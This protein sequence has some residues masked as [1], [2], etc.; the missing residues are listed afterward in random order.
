MG[1]C[2]F[3]NKPRLNRDYSSQCNEHNGYLYSK[4]K[5]AYGS[6]QTPKEYE[7]YLQQDPTEVARSL[8][9]CRI[10]TK[11]N[12]FHVVRTRYANYE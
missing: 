1:N 8:P 6:K 10:E 12:D 2:C 3:V 9:S 7:E 4:N 5:Y 11:R